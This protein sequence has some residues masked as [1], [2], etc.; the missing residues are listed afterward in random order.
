MIKKVLLLLC[1]LGFFVYLIL[2]IT[3]FNKPDDTRLCRNVNLVIE[4]S[5]QAGF[6]DAKE[7]MELLKRE[8]VYP[9]GKK[10]AEINTRQIENTLL[11]NPFIKKADC[12]IT[13]GGDVTIRLEQ[14]LPVLRVMANNG[15]DY[16]LD[17]TGHIMS[18]SR[19]AA[20]LPVATGYITADYAERYLVDIAKMLKDDAFWDSQVEQINVLK[21]GDVELIPRVG[22]HVLSMGSPKYMDGKLERM[23][24]FYK[25][26]MPQVG[27]NKYESI[28]LEFD[29][30]I[31]C[32]KKK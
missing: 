11:K 18:Q 16:Y 17:N 26:V 3:C 27:W 15:E 25:D 23:K 32:K 13:S 12:Y 29:N 22:D 5:V 6:I 30:Q 28:N 14:R 7:T 1:L 4:D 21:N 31:I 10:R 19:Y 2:A 9:V 24:E 8:K 20:H